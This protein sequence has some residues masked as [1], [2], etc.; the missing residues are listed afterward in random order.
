VYG[1]SDGQHLWAVGFEGTILESVDGGEHWSPRASGTQSGLDSVY[2]SSDGQHLWAV[3]ERG[4]ILKS[5]D[6]GEH[7]SPRASGTKDL[8]R[9]VYG[10]SDGQHLWAVGF[11]GTILESVDGGEH[12]SPRASGTQNSLNSVHST[13]D[14]QRMWA[15]GFEGTILESRDRGEHWSPHTSGTRNALW[16]VY[17][18]SDGQHLWA[19]G[20]EGTILKSADGGEHWSSRA[21]GTVYELR[22][23]YGASD[24]QHLWVVGDEG[25]ILESVDGG[26]H[27]SPRNS[28]TQSHLHSVFGASDGQHLWAVGTGGTILESADG[29]ALWS[30]RASGTQDVLNSVYG[31]NDGQHLW[32]VGTGGTILESVDGGEHWSPRT[33]GTQNALNSVYT[34]SDGQHLWAVG[35]AGTILQSGNR[36]EHWS[37][38]ASGTQNHL[39][40]VYGSSDGQRL[41]VVGLEGTILES[42]DG[43]EHWSPRATG[44]QTLGHKDFTSVYGTNDGQRLWAVGLEGMILEATRNGMSPFV[45]EAHLGSTLRLNVQP[46]Q[47]PVSRIRARGRTAYDAGHNVDWRK[48][49]TCQA[50]GQSGWWNCPV[51]MKQLEAKNGDTVHFRI[52]VER[53]GGTD[54]YEFTTV[55]NPGAF[56]REHLPWFIAGAAAI[57]WIGVPSVFLFVKPLWNLR[58]YRALKLNQ[59]EKLNLPVFGDTIQFLLGLVTVLPHYIRHHKTLDAWLRENVAAFRQTWNTELAQVY[60]PLP[61]RIG[62]E[63]SGDLLDRPTS[64]D[65]R[66]RITGARATFQIVGP[67]GAGKTTLARQM[68]LWAFNDELGDYPILPIWVDEELDPDRKPLV[69]VVKGKLAATLETEEIEDELFTALFKKRRLLVIVDRLSERSKTTQTHIQTIYR[70]AKIGLLVV[71]SRTSL[72]FDG[73]KCINIYPEPL[74]SSTLLHFVTSLLRILW[75]EKTGTRAFSKIEEQTGLGNRLAR[76]ISVRTE[77]GE[78]EVP[79]IPLPVRLFVEQAVQLVDDGRALDELPAS[80]P[81]VYFLHLRRV[82]PQDPSLPHY[83]HN[84]RMI[85]IA[86]ILGRLAL[87]PNF[88]PKEFSRAQALAALKAAGESATET[89][90]PIERLKLNNVLIEKEGGFDIRLRFALDPIAEFLAAAEYQEQCGSDQTKWDAVMERSSQAPGFQS[91]LKLVRQALKPYDG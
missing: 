13:S 4:T 90:D 87:E 53:E 55:Y 42:V 81:E 11:E 25:T 52:D 16:L 75:S 73:A 35:G 76:L 18:T 1:T 83:L 38:R 48:E 9:S 37:P 8:L 84:D 56:V 43:G 60:V 82:N 77:R 31:A 33:S 67:G 61:I 54:Q 29:G 44:I 58:I 22:S 5:A 80:L 86:K 71:T 59:I 68:A 21:S 78:E 72:T 85:K 49:V 14:G 57:V 10:A 50:V 51:E 28:N 91:A 34:A 63:F 7:W 15:V 47:W 2:G 45:R 36:G 46:G 64:D 26:E 12:W 23:V 66:K 19:V 30:P 40:S 69:T 41:W 88:I 79:L 6:G 24:G 27:W 65:I 39:D 3:G 89:S 17:S 74:D 62:N 32:A 20:D 70:S